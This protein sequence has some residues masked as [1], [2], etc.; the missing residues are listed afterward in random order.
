MRNTTITRLPR[1]IAT[2]FPSATR[3][4]CVHERDR[5]F[6]SVSLQRGVS[7]EPFKWIWPSTKSLKGLEEVDPRNIDSGVLLDLAE[8][9]G[10]EA[11]TAALKRQG[12]QFFPGEEKLTGGIANLDDYSACEISQKRDWR[13]LFVT[14]FYFGCEADDPSTVWAFNARAN[15][16]G[17]R[18]NAIFSSD[19]GHFDVPDMT[20]VVPEADHHEFLALQAFDVDPEAAIAGCVER[21]DA[22]GDDA[23]EYAQ[24]MAAHEGPRND[25]A[26]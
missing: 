11:F 20:E 14:P 16:L 12:G 7:N 10:G 1:S 26:L 2:A 22:L 17:A 8:K 24:E 25:Q 15:P 23:L 4:R 3:G 18:L 19:I 21:I 5:W 13:D 9:Y 6:E